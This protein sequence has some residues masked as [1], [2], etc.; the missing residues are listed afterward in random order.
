MLQPFGL[1]KNWSPMGPQSVG[2]G[3]S[4]RESPP[5]EARNDNVFWSYSPRSGTTDSNMANVRSFVLLVPG[6]GGEY[7]FM[8]FCYQSIPGYHVAWRRV[9]RQWVA[10]QKSGYSGS[11]A[12]RSKFV[13]NSSSR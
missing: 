7:G 12:G 13:R 10:S 11:V 2:T 8:G 4:H 5:E 3:M 6:S 9:G 1:A